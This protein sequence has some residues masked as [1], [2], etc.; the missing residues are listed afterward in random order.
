MAAPST[1]ATPA[2]DEQ[3]AAE[4]IGPDLEAVVAVSIPL[5]HGANEGCSLREEWELDR[6]GPGED[7]SL[8]VGL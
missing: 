4:E 2:A 1:D 3:G 7:G 6:S 8:D 5:G